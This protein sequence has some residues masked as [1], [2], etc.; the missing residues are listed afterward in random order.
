MVAT[1]TVSSS[2]AST[3]LLRESPMFRS[4]A[5]PAWILSLFQ[6]LWSWKVCQG[7][8]GIDIGYKCHCVLEDNENDAKRRMKWWSAMVTWLPLGIAAGALQDEFEEGGEFRGWG[9][10]FCFLIVSTATEQHHQFFES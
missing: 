8:L 1:S 2:E 4:R 10:A 6:T 9:G 7:F 3:G 5:L